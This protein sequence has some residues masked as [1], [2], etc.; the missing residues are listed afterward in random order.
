M[1]AHQTLFLTLTNKC[2]GTIVVQDVSYYVDVACRC[3]YYVELLHHHLL[4]YE[5][6][7]FTIIIHHPTINN[8]VVYYPKS[9]IYRYLNCITCYIHK[10]SSMTEYLCCYSV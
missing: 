1:K 6:M 5:Y 8:S 2:S 4:F 7:D 10:L 3:R 9:V